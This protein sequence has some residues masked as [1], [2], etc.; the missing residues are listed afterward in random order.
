MFRTNLK[1]EAAGLDDSVVIP[2]NAGIAFLEQKAGDP[3]FFAA[4]FRTLDPGVRR[5]DE[6]VCLDSDVEIGSRTYL[7][8]AK[9]VYICGVAA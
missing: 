3:V 6:R 8:T 4:S 9:H 5:D 1:N 7:K 2:A